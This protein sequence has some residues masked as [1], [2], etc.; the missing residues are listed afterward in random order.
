MAIEKLECA[1]GVLVGGVPAIKNAVNGLVDISGSSDF[2]AIQARLLSGFNKG[3]VVTYIVSGDSTRDYA[4]T[5]NMPYYY[6]QLSKVDLNL[7]DN[8]KAG[9]SALNWKN[10]TGD[11]TLQMAIDATSGT[12]ESTIMEFSY[13]INDG[14]AGATSEQHRLAVC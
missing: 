5:Q 12:G 2:S 13:I 7:V 8:S 14:S 9:Q 4:E 6:E 3:E 10:N 11:A 1:S